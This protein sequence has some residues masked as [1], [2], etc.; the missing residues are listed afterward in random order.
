MP[1]FENLNELVGVPAAY[2]KTQLLTETWQNSDLKG[3]LLTIDSVIQTIYNSFST[4]HLQ[5]AY[6]INLYPCL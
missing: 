3:K 2:R 5:E 1:N 4:E 6:D